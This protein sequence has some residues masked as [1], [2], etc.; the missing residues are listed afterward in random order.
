MTPTHNTLIDALYH[1]MPWDAIDTVVFDVGNV[2]LRFDPAELAAKVFP[3]DEE[4]RRTVQR[5]ATGTPYWPMLDRGTLSLADAP[6]RMAGFETGAIPVLQRFMRGWLELPPIEEGIAFLRAV[7]A[8]GKRTCI[9][10]NYNAEAYAIVRAKYAFLREID[11]EVISSTVGL[12][13]PDPAIFRLAEARLGRDPSRTL[14]IDDSA[15]NV[16]AALSLGWHAFWNNESGKLT[17][18]LG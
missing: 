18:F 8:Q 3:D 14:F 6:A 4:A 16:E 15:A 1:S 11:G 10:S 5:L 17:R 2:L 12:L 13:K 7:R 9:L